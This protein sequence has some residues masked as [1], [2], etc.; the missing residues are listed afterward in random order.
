MWI[1]RSLLIVSCVV[2]VSCRD[3]V[4]NQQEAMLTLAS[5]VT[6]LSSAIESTCRYKSPPGNVRDSDLISLSTK[7]DP[8]LAQPFVGY[9]LRAKCEDKHGVVL[10]CNRAGTRALIEDSAC[11]SKLDFHHWEKPTAVPCAYTVPVAIMCPSEQ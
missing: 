5:A 8:S 1:V 10:V 3:S 2:L 7:H 4:A 6:K 11:T 9:T